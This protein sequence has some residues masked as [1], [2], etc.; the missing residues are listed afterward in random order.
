LRGPRHGG[1]LAWGSG[2]ILRPADA[3]VAFMPQ[4]PYIPLGS[5]RHALV[6]PAAKTDHDDETIAPP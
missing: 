5:L 6:Y 3:K 2:R 4:Q 1:P